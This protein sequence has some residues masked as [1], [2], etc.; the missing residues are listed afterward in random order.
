MANSHQGDDP[1][2]H[3]A[4]PRGTPSPIKVPVSGQT[5][6]GSLSIDASRSFV[7]PHLDH[8]PVCGCFRLDLLCSLSLLLALWLPPGL[9]WL[10][11][12]WLSLGIP[13]VTRGGIGGF[14]FGR[15]GWQAILT[16]V[17]P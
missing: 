10:L 5:R 3:H 6:Q 12:T 2:F 4:A 13:L 1:S 7:F 14:G 8:T 9:L 15:A 16:G 17:D 11:A